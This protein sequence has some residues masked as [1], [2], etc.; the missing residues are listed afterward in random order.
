MIE[1]NQTEQ[2]QKQKSKN[3]YQEVL[4]DIVK[5][6]DVSDLSTKY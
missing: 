3:Q 1:L 2:K 5:Q 6:F 4:N